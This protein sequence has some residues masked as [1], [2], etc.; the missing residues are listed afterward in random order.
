M[1]DDLKPHFDDVQAHYDL[2]D[3]F[4]RIW[5]GP[6]M[7]YSCGWWDAA[8]G[9]DALALIRAQRRKLDYFADRLGLPAK[10]LQERRRLAP[11]QTG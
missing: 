3:D 4:F 7:V 5:L 1:P 6:E 9:P 10:P 11:R 8:D 2:S